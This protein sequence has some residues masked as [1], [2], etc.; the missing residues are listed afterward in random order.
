[1]LCVLTLRLRRW[2]VVVAFCHG[3]RFV[4]RP[5]FRS[6]AYLASA[7]HATA[8]GNTYYL[9]HSYGVPVQMELLACLWLRLLFWQS[10]RCARSIP[11]SAWRG[12]T[13][14]GCWLGPPQASKIPGIFCS[15]DCAKRPS[16]VHLSSLFVVRDVKLGEVLIGGGAGGGV[17]CMYIRL[18]TYQTY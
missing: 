4:A 8:F 9:S 1:M 18:V 11:R 12:L 7:L 3:E 15:A 10:L 16:R 5:T 2:R 6:R 17:H 14:A 13:A